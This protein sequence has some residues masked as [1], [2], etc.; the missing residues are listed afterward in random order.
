VEKYN[1][2]IKETQIITRNIVFQLPI[3]KSEIHFSTLVENGNS[4]ADNHSAISNTLGSIKPNNA[5]IATIANTTKTIGYMSA[6]IYLF[7]IS[8]MYSYS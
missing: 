5:I 6:H 4:D 3:K 8:I 7:F 2:K 1:H